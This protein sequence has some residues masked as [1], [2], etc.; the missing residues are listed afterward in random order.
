MSC[1]PLTTSRWLP[2]GGFPAHGGIS[3]S[4][5]G[6]AGGGGVAT[7][8]GTVDKVVGAPFLGVSADIWF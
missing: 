5:S 4:G 6:A 1:S 3:Y 2:F 7:F 8:L